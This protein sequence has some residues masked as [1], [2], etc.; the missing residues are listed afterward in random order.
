MI[1]IRCSVSVMDTKCS[2][3]RDGV[4]LEALNTEWLAG[5]AL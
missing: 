5:R 4:H 3:L 1:Q 2:V